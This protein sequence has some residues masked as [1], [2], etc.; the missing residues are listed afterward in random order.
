MKYFTQDLYDE[1]QVRGCMG[2]YFES[3]EDLQKEI[4][5]YALEGR[6][7]YKESRDRFE[8]MRPHML[9]FLPPHLLKYVY[10]E[11]IMDCNIYSP[12]MKAEI[13]TWKNEWDMK[14]KTVCD[15]YWAHYDSIS[16]QLP[17]EV[18]RLDKEIKLHD[19]TILEV[20]VYEQKV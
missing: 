4:S 5:W 1:M 14:W 15:Q 6:D 10:D 16:G 12:V 20:L 2:S 3:E 9:R 8:W 13:Q 11:S 19:A 18:Q 7:F 17:K